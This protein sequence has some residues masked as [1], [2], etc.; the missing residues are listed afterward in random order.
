MKVRDRGDPGPTEEGRESADEQG[1]T[2]AGEGDSTH[3]QRE[4]PGTTTLCGRMLVSL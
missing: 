3:G 1:E 2:T 4:G